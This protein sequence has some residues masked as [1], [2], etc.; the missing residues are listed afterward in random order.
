M[1]ICLVEKSGLLRRSEAKELFQ[2]HCHQRDSSPPR[3]HPGL[4]WWK[5]SLRLAHQLIAWMAP[6]FPCSAP[7]AGVAEAHCHRARKLH[8]QESPV[9]SWNVSQ[10]RKPRQEGAGTWGRSWRAGVCP[11]GSVGNGL[12]GQAVGKGASLPHNPESQTSLE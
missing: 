10:M 1:S 3:S 12:T 8:G 2:K 5:L 7:V 6:E 9:S 4:W 11:Q